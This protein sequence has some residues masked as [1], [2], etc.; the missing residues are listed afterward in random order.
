MIRRLFLA[1]V[2][3]LCLAGMAAVVPAQQPA[4]QMAAD[5]NA[6]TVYITKTGKRYHRAG[7]RYLTSTQRAVSLKEA[8]AMGLTP[9]KVCQPPE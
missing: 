8:K 5:T 1:L 4:P 7:C 9:C 3:F 6:Q 2:A